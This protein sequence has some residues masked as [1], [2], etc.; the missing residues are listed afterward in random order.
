VRNEHVQ[1]IVR[2]LL[3]HAADGVAWTDPSLP[4]GA[5]FPAADYADPAHLATEREILFKR[6]PQAVALTADLPEPGSFITRDQFD[7]PLVISRGRDGVAR[8]MANVCAHRG[9]QVVDQSRGCSRR[10]ACAYHAWTYDEAG[11]LVGVPDQRSFPRVEVPGPGL[12]PIPAVEA[13]G[14]IWVDPGAVGAAI[15]GPGAALEPPELGT[16]ADDFEQFDIGGHRHWRSHRFDLAMNWKLV[17]DTFLE[18]YHFASLH[19]N[20]VGP[21]FF[22]NLCV[23]DR[24]GPIGEH[25]RHVIPR[26]SLAELADQPPETWDIVPHTALVYVLLPATVFVMQI[27]H[28]EL[29]RVWPQGDDPNRS[30]C[31]LDF[32]IPVGPST[33]SS[34][35]HWENNWKLTIDTVEQ[36]DFKAMAGVQQ[37]VASGAIDRVRFGA[38][39]P[40]L[41]MYHQALQAM[42]SAAGGTSADETSAGGRW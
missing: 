12:A 7:V 37:G 28:I 23:A 34:E 39:E 30:W 18:P 29:W 20:T 5:E 33:E 8:A 25:V 4:E 35:R 3:S 31:D 41:I 15:S 6:R 14:I 1:P 36:E 38:N 11:T 32:Y 16:I 42:L 9:G 17:V 26:R 21:I 27:D 24:H 22:P 19:R 10:H 2:T 13:D 40:A